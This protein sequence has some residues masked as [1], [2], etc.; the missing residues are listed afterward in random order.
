[1]DYV[2]LIYDQEPPGPVPDELLDA[3][4]QAFATYL[5]DI[6][7]RGVL[8]MGTPLQPSPTASTVRKRGGK[9]L[10]TDGPFAETKEVLAG[11]LLVDVPGLDE[12]RAVAAGIPV[13]P[14]GCVEVRPVSARMEELMAKYM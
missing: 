2:L 9:P 1:M 10:S 6:T 3:H 8:K 7:A 5:K 12:A 14:N 11:F 13:S 4:A